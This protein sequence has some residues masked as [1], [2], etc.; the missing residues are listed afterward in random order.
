[1]NRKQERKD[2]RLSGEV[3]VATQ[4]ELEEQLDALEAAIAT[5]ATK[6]KYSDKEITYNSFD[7]LVRARDFLLKKLGRSTGKRRANPPF[8]KGL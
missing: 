3:R 7:D 2:N 5:G 8:C 6:I 4:Q 1:M